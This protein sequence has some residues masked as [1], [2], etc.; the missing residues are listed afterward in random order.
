MCFWHEIRLASGSQC[1][2]L[3][4]GEEDPWEELRMLD[5]VHQAESSRMEKNPLLLGEDVLGMPKSLNLAFPLQETQGWS[6][7]AMEASKLVLR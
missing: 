7:C 1:S 4:W 5:S 6:T 2:S 3:L